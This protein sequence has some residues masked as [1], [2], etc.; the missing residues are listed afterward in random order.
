M[1]AKEICFEGGIADASSSYDGIVPALAFLNN[2]SIWHSGSEENAASSSLFVW[3]EFKLPVKYPIKLSFEP[4]PVTSQQ[5]TPKQF[6]F[7]GTNDKDCSKT[8]Q[9]SVICDGFYAEE[10]ETGEIRGCEAQKEKVMDSLRRHREFRCLGIKILAV[11]WGQ[12]AAMRNVK[13]WN[14]Q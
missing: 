13:M 1:K 3:Y 9:W 5:Q 12:F 11:H 14:L 8:S 4:R 7:V 2:G 6:Q 10:P